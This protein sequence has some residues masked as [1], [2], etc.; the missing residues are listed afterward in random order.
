MPL[1]DVGANALVNLYAEAGFPHL[2]CVVR[3]PVSPCMKGIFAEDSQILRLEEGNWNIGDKNCGFPVPPQFCFGAVPSL[4]AEVGR[5]SQQILAAIDQVMA[6]VLDEMA[7]IQ[8]EVDLSVP[9]RGTARLLDR[10][11]HISCVD[12]RESW[13]VQEHVPESFIGLCA[14]QDSE[15]VLVVASHIKRTTRMKHSHPHEN[16]LHVF[17]Q[18][19]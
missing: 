19:C 17:W 16:T 9:C 5:Q 1:D 10:C 3:D 13:V 15:P 14:V 4:L 18:V 12:L 6:A 11:V 8:A 7:I 2:L